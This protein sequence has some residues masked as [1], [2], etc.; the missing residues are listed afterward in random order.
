M[1]EERERLVDIIVRGSASITGQETLS[2]L[3]AGQERHFY[4]GHCPKNVLPG[5]RVYFVDQGAA[6]G[7]AT[8][9]S[10][11]PRRGE[12][13]SG[14]GTWDAFIIT[15]PWIPVEPPEPVPSAFLR[16]QWRWRYV[17]GAIDALLR[18]KAP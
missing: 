5:D 2:S 12:S 15:G 10:F 6:Y 7:Y 9:K 17:L 14:V 3:G 4:R 1:L 18:S 13:A 11:E 16:G 8:W